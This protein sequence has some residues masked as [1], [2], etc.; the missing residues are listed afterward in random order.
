MGRREPSS[1]TGPREPEPL[2]CFRKF[3]ANILTEISGHSDILSTIVTFYI[4]HENK[5]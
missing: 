1:I 4:I 3:R 2:T 5:F